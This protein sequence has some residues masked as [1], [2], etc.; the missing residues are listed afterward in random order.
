MNPIEISIDEDACVGCGL[1]V[2]ECPTKVFEKQE[3][4]AAIKVKS[5]KECF[6]CLSCS[7]IC[8]AT[9]IKH[10]GVHLSESYYHDP[11]SLEL[12]SKLG[13]ADHSFH[14]PSDTPHIQK[15]VEDLGIRLLSVTSVL[16]QT[17]GSSLPSVG[18]MAGISLASQL[19][20][21]QSPQS[22]EDAL[23]L[24]SQTFSP[25]WDIRTSLAGDSLTITIATCFVRD[26]CKK[27]NIELGG[28][29][30]KLFSNYVAGYLSKAAKIRP[31]LTGIAPS[32]TSCV[33]TIKIHGAR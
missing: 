1:C 6:G 3:S 8:P 31:R 29:M 23:K 20:R 33:Y 2:D 26:V 13:T 30:C 25:S 10:S 19:P 32:D 22:L 16:K 5:V 27:G 21:Y 9:A 18:T 11:A 15:A 14:V 12:A 24:F 28:D 4:G 7:E 17:L